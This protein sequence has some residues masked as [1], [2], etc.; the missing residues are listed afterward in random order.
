M[1]NKSHLRYADT[2]DLKPK[3]LSYVVFC[4]ETV[5]V[6]QMNVLFI[7]VSRSSSIHIL[8]EHVGPK[9]FFKFLF[10]LDKATLFLLPFA[11]DSCRSWS[12]YPIDYTCGN[13][14]MRKKLYGLCNVNLKLVLRVFSNQLNR[15]L[16]I[17]ITT[18]LSSSWW[19]QIIH[20]INLIIY[21]NLY[22]FCRSC[23][24]FV[25]VPIII[26]LF[27]RFAVF[28]NGSISFT[29]MEWLNVWN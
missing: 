17:L 12:T 16:S 3:I 2:I 20:S 23:E 5:A 14:L 25:S 26:W 8:K 1:N 27:S 21:S 6:V 4:F 11:G 10:F 28:C 9:I 22:T 15:L 13:L 19:I 18:T 24:K 29:T 7:K